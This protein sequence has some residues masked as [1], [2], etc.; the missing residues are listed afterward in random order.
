M[1]TYIVRAFA[2]S[3]VR[4]SEK[5]YVETML[6]PFTMNVPRHF[7]VTAV[8]YIISINDVAVPK[9]LVLNVQL[10]ADSLSDAL[11]YA[12]H[13]ATYFL[14]SLSCTCNAAVGTPRA[15]WGYDA[16]PGLLERDMILLI[17]DYRLCI[18]TRRLDRG[19]W[20]ALLNQMFHGKWLEPNG[21]E[22]S[23]QRLQRAVEAFRRGVTDTDDILDEFLVHWSSLET[24]DVV[25]RRVFNHEV[26][27][28]YKQCGNCET[29]F[30]YCPVCGDDGT[31][32]VTHK[33]TGIEDVF[34][35]LRQPAKYNEL[36]KLRNG[37]SHGYM[38]IEKCRAGA[39]EN[40]ELVRKAVLCMIMKIV[41]LGDDIQTAILGQL[42]LKSKTV[43]HFRLYFKGNFEPGDPSRYDTH[44][45]VEVKDAGLEVK[46]F[47][48][49]LALNPKWSFTYTN[50]SVTLMRREL[51]GD[52]AASFTFEVGR[53]FEEL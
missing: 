24:L 19:H 41:G 31:F 7:S 44:P 29:K 12:Q 20:H 25:Y 52:E 5:P 23:M 33:H 32:R 50:C 28:H 51:C 9:G 10:D 47:G 3:S 42:G 35:T 13:A 14:S 34:F 15:L 11:E 46:K 17:Y 26:A 45:N 2:E 53:T 22:D 37:I 18:N 30:K 16:T 8:D 48:D 36:R 49:K 38:T 1:P 27:H 4:L 21:S 40:I 6:T 43:P 39:A